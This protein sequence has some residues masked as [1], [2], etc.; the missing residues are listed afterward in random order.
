MTRGAHTVTVVGGRGA[1]GTMLAEWAAADGDG[2]GDAVIV[3][4]LPGRGAGDSTGPS[5]AGI[6]GAGIDGAG[7]DGAGIDTV[8]SGTVPGDVTA[9]E[10]ALVSVLARTDVLILAVPESVAVACLPI[11]EALLPAGALVVDTLSVKSRYAAALD[12]VGFGH[13]AVGVNPMFAPSLSPDG[14]AVAVV[15]YDGRPVP[16]DLREPWTRR[17]AR[18]VSVSADE[19]DRL[20]ATTQALTHATVL[21]FGRALGHLDVS[22]DDLLSLA[23]PPHLVTLALLSRVASGTPE[24]YREIQSA[25]PYAEQARAALAAGVR[26]VGKAAR[27]GDSAFADLLDRARD[28]LR[29][30]T[31][32]LRATCTALFA[33]PALFPEP[34]DATPEGQPCPRT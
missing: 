33:D 3:V 6:D 25:N 28:P 2:D 10:A 29:H 21:A 27:A 9:P 15:A 30:R 18:V 24:V 22:V 34:T 26:E 32:E 23:A 31:E 20:T 7:I 13:R 12:E 17:G 14:R 16:A 1:V 11:V 19:H 8:A 4:V 5:G